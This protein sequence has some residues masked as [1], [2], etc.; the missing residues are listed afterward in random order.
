M[1]CIARVIGGVHY[2][3]DILGGFLVG[4]IGALAL[5]IPAR[6]IGEFIT[7]YVLKIAAYIKL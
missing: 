7:P 2:F 6:K 4:G 3:G 5:R 1:T